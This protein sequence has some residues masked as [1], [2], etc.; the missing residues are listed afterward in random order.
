MLSNIPACPG[1]EAYAA[2]VPD[3]TPV[4]G[5]VGIYVFVTLPARGS[6]AEDGE[7]SRRHS[8]GEPSGIQQVFA[9]Q[10][11]TEGPLCTMTTTRAAMKLQ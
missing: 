2:I 8:D 9:R 1:V 11:V 4:G 7:E 10:S 5:A 6:F 3:R